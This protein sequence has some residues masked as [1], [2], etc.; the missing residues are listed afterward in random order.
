VWVYDSA[1]ENPIAFVG[2]LHYAAITDAAWS[3]DGRTLVVS[4]SDGYCSAGAYTGAFS[5][6]TCAVSDTNSP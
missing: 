6:S 5:S 2:G 3:P 4:S 1:E